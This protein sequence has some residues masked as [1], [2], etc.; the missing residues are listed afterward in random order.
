VPDSLAW[1]PRD[2]FVLSAHVARSTWIDRLLAWPGSRLAAPL[3]IFAVAVASL[4]VHASGAVAH[5]HEMAGHRGAPTRIIADRRLGPYVASVWTDAEV[6]SGPMYVMLEAADGQTFIPPSAVR[7][8]VAP[9]SGRRSEVLHRTHSE[10]TRRGARFMTDVAFDR[11][12]RWNLRVLV[13]GS[14]GGG[15]LTSQV[16][17]VPNAATGPFMLVLSVLPFL[18]VTGVWWRAAV[19]RRRIAVADT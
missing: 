12:E 1:L 16:E 5:R 10:P 9:V 15:Q 2:L 14:A 17:A 7:V 3:L 11:A 13:E 19:A 18:A 6:G 4:A 8:G